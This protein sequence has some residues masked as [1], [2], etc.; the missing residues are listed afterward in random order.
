MALHGNYFNSLAEDARPVLLKYMRENDLTDAEK[1][2]LEFFKSWDLM[3]SPDSKGQ[4]IY[5]CWWDSLETGI[6]KDELSKV[7]PQ[8]PMPEEQTTMEIL[9]RDS[10]LKYADD[11][12]TPQTETLFDMV[13]GAFKKAAAELAKKEAEG[14]LE[15]AKFKNPT[16]YHL[17]KDLKGFARPG[18]NVGGN[19]NIVNAVTHSHGPSWRMIVHLT[20][21]TE[22]YGVYP[23]GQSG[24]PGS[25]FYDNYID[26]WV[27][28]KYNKLWF[29]RDGD[30][31]DRNVKW[32]MK[33]AGRS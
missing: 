22:A 32:V 27:A 20:S 26:D 25:R 4:T 23:G 3:A 24:N 2:Y 28:G 5:Q 16:V 33:F 8:A 31:T 13:T 17:I 21:P 10:A 1:K 19:G 30:R 18:L 7:S 9:Q 15:W 12:N 6:W 14:K 11:I 29:M